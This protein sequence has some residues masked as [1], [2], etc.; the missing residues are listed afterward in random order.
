MGLHRKMQR[1]GRARGCL[2]D[3]HPLCPD[4]I[5]VLVRIYLPYC[6]KDTGEGK[7]KL[8]ELQG[9]LPVRGVIDTSKVFQVPS[10]LW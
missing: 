4:S 9:D 1:L 10:P 2:G 3:R 7:S 5:D 8:N 6:P